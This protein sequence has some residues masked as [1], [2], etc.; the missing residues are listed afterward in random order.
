MVK[1]VILRGFLLLENE[2]DRSLSLMCKVTG[3]NS[4]KEMR[5]GWRWSVSVDGSAEITGLPLPVHSHVI[6][7]LS[8]LDKTGSCRQGPLLPVSLKGWQLRGA[9]SSDH[10][11]GEYSPFYSHGSAK[12][13]LQFLEFLW[14]LSCSHR[15][16]TQLYST[17]K[18]HITVNQQI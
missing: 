16:R 13:G 11:L 6:T 17:H 4:E 5:A 12:T 7:R 14:T 1:S 2:W 9:C 8:W 3:E 18:I 15:A 10:N